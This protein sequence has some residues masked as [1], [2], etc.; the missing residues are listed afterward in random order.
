MAP[1]RL[2]LLLLGAINAVALPVFK[3]PAQLGALDYHFPG[4]GASSSLNTGLRGY[5]KLDE[6]S[7]TRN[8]SAGVS[9]LTDNNTVLATAAKINDGALFVAA[10]S[11]FLSCADSAPLSLG[12]GVN[13]SFGFWVNTTG[14]AG[15]HGLISKWDDSGGDNEYLIYYD[16]GSD[17][18]L[19]L[20]YGNDNIQYG[21]F[22]SADTIAV[23]TTAFV[24]V[25]YNGSTIEIHIND[26][27]SPSSTAHTQGVRDSTSTFRMGV[28][29]EGLAWLHNSWLD[30]PGLWNKALST[31]EMTSLYNAG[32]GITCCPFARL[33][34]DATIHALLV[35]KPGFDLQRKA[36]SAGGSWT[37]M[38]RGEEWSLTE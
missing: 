14:C 5:W 26:D 4:G 2:I 27:G 9:H 1:V 21:P 18:I 13:W 22:I 19:M 16:G 20:L 11:E 29:N 35:G 30:E 34:M 32:T 33:F 17:Q 38:V 23:N 24:V 12:A 10:N 28:A 31:I 8:D 7:G 6:A 25:R 36:F 15:S 3:D 37:V